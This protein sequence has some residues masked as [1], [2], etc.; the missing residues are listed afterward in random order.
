[1]YYTETGRICIISSYSLVVYT[2]DHG[3]LCL[4]KGFII[5]VGGM[6]IEGHFYGC[7]KL[8]FGGF[9]Q[10]KY[11]TKPHGTQNIALKRVFH[12]VQLY[13]LGPTPLIFHPPSCR[14]LSKADQSSGPRSGHLP[15]ECGSVVAGAGPAASVLASAWT[16]WPACRQHNHRPPH[17]LLCPAHLR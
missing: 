6:K 13:I 9:L 17:C 5:Y 16:Q 11:G 14:W 8:Y 10:I 1:M 15:P 3:L 7:F 4:W 2:K 12:T